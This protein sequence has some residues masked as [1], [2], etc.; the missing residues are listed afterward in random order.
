MVRK[1]KLKTLILPLLATLT[2]GLAPFTP[3]PHFFEK[4]SWL[5]TG[6][7]FAPIDVFDLVMHGA[8]WVWLVWT[9]ISVFRTGKE[10]QTAS[11]S[12]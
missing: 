6:H 11:S 1:E 12:L 2:L 7:S 5:F 10:K 9:L 8:P 3:L 4:I